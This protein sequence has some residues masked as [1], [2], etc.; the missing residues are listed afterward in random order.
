MINLNS[1]CVHHSGVIIG[2]FLN[3]FNKDRVSPNHDFRYEL[4]HVRNC[5]HVVE[6]GKCD[7]I[8]LWQ[9]LVKLE[10]G[11]LHEHNSHE[12]ARNSKKLSKVRSKIYLLFA[13]DMK[14][15]SQ[16]KVM[17][18]ASSY[19]SSICLSSAHSRVMPLRGASVSI[20]AVKLKDADLWSM[21][22]SGT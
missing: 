16:H 21:G 1:C 3:S 13:I 8:T 12:D 2:H 4:P 5:E 20:F 14:F 18:A 7:G 15:G 11:Q 22:S 17:L 9:D 19:L 6:L 10:I